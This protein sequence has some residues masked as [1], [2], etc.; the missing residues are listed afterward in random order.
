MHIIAAHIP[1][2]PRG[3]YRPRC[4]SLFAA[5]LQPITTFRRP[6]P[7]ITEE[8]SAEDALDRPSEGNRSGDFA[9]PDQLIC[10]LRR[11]PGSNLR[12]RICS[13]VQDRER[14]RAIAREVTPGGAGGT[15]SGR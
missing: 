6:E 13:T 3:V 12:Q 5:K 4:L 11:V 15:D 2:G 10:D 7:P 9:R 1:R 8:Q 14:A